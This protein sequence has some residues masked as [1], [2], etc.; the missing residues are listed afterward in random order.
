MLGYADAVMFIKE[1]LLYNRMG[2]YAQIEE[3]LNVPGKATKKTLSRYF[4]SFKSVVLAAEDAYAVAEDMIDKK[5]NQTIAK[6]G[7]QYLR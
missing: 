2:M 3:I 6:Y 5:I 1:M 4:K 7:N